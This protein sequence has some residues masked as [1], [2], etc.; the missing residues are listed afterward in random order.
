MAVI[1]PRAT[2]PEKVVKRD[3]KRKTSQ[4]EKLQMRSVAECADFVA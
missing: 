4:G 1:K 3:A 2:A